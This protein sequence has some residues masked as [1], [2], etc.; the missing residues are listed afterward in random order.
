M[1]GCYRGAEFSPPQRMPPPSAHR[2]PNLHKFRPASPEHV[3]QSTK[4]ISPGRG[5]SRS[6]ANLH[7]DVRVELHKSLFTKVDTLYGAT[8][9]IFIA[10]PAFQPALTVPS[11]E[12]VGIASNSQTVKIARAPY[13]WP[14]SM[15]RNVH[16]IVVA[17]KISLACKH[18]QRRITNLEK[19]L[20][21]HRQFWIPSKAQN[22]H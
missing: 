6:S 11:I 15:S 8:K 2:V 19:L 7:F 16:E 17:Q 3:D 5:S 14:R 20:P 1:R 13:S 21:F 22:S 10:L 4:A 18:P 12:G 9:P